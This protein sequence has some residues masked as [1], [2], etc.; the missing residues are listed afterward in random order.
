MILFIYFYFYINYFL[1]DSGI[2]FDV[3]TMAFDIVYD[4]LYIK[5]KVYC[6]RA[7]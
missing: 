1:L 7:C 3:R 5:F 2:D 6:V 4:L